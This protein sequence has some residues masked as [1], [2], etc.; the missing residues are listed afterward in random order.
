MTSAPLAVHGEL[1]FRNRIVR[2]VFIVSTPRSGS[3]LLFETLAKASALF[4][5]GRE[6]HMRIERVA[7]F[8]PGK[9]R[10]TSN[11]LVEADATAEAVERLAELFYSGLEDRDGRPPAREVRMLEK[12]P[13]NALRVPFFNAAWPD[14]LFVYLYRDVRQTLASMMEAW[15]SG[16]FRTYPML[17]GWSGYAWSL[18]LV[19]DWQRLIGRPL[20]EVVANQWAITTSILLDDLERLPRERVRVAALDDIIAHPQAAIAA[21]ARFLDVE[22]D[23]QLEQ[24]LPPSTMT[25]SPPDPNKWRRFEALIEPV[26]PIVR[27]ADARARSFLESLRP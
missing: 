10:W 13:K 23:Q 25:L 27:D 15:V 21:L 20:A 5:T 8:H 1:S 14:A 16:R 4:T 18:L 19:P 26:L 12:T 24:Q 22:W 11:R 9:R 6:S 17:P 7:D 2:P 3:T